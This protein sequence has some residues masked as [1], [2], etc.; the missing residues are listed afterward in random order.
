MNKPQ[1]SCVLITKNEE[2]V[3]PRLF[4]SL[5]EFKARG[6]NCCV[7]D[8]GSIDATVQIAKNWGCTVREMGDAF[9]HTLTEFEVEHINKQ[10]LVSPETEAPI[11][12]EG[13]SY[14]DFSA[15]RNEAAKLAECNFIVSVDADEVFTKLDIDVLNELIESGHTQFVYPFVFSH[16][17][18]GK[19]LISFTQSKAYDRSVCHWENRIHEML[20]LSDVSK[21]NHIKHL[22]EQM[23]HLEHFQNKA[24]NRSSYLVGLAADCFYNP[25][26]SRNSFYFAR[27]MFWT[28]RP[29]SAAKEFERHL[30][31]DATNFE[32]MESMMFLGDI[33]G[34]MDQPEKQVEWFHEAMALVPYRREPLIKLAQTYLRRNQPIPAQSFAKAALEIPWDESYGS[35]K[36][37]YDMEPH[38]V[39]YWSAGWQGDIA[40]AREHLLKCLDYDRE[41]PMYTHDTKYYFQYPANTIP[42]WMHFREQTF[43]FETA[44]QMESVI[45]LGSWKGKSTHAICSSG[46]PSVTAIDHWR[47]SKDEPEAHAEAASG[48][49]FE[50]FKRNVGHFANLKWISADI[51]DAVNDI[52]DKSVDMIFIDAGH[53]YEEVK[54][55]ILKWKNKAKILICGHDYGYG[56]PGVQWAVDELLGEVETC[57]TIWYKYMV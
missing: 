25:I 29:W 19:S 45:E 52:P 10:F 2:A 21:H 55:D 8:T 43:L 30:T 20:K 17:P 4:A 9:R 51:N 11:V 35:P 22:T 57:H 48:T 15:A 6:G 28:G 44:K 7:L 12:F 31:L 24:S 38:E 3:L 32:K 50:D 37:F 36:D 53:T 49:V 42:G 33:Y 46:C 14:F 39:L 5:E 34:A 47:G 40:G 23:Y 54:N 13:E 27:E 56:W 1:F 18:D 26:N 41:N 16:S